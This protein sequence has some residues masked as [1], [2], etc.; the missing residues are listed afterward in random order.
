MPYTDLHTHI[1]P[2]LDD[3]PADLEEALAL[4][5]ALVAAGFST[6]V[7]TPHC[8]EGKPSADVILESLQT[9]Q[10]ELARLQIPLAVLPGAEYAIDLHLPK[11]LE[12]GALLTLNG[13]RFLLLET[14]AFQPLPPFTGELIFE[15]RLRGCYPI[16]AHPERCA[17]FQ[18]DPGR[19]E[20][21]IRSGAL[22][23]ITLS[24]LTG[25]MG[26]AAAR[27]AALFFHSGLAHILATDAHTAAGRL[28]VIAKALALAEKLGGPGTADLMLQERPAA[29]LRDHLPPLPEPEEPLEPR[30]KCAKRRLF[31]KGRKCLRRFT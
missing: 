28:S 17:A 16:L 19:L 3:G 20:R 18:E 24:S 13:S 9:L 21:L 31:R 14:P 12:A 8:Y 5:R 2:G 26:P 15:L 6:V 27:A 29:I 7:A 10:A 22:T 1:L 11:R 23:Q 4:A 30:S 25:A